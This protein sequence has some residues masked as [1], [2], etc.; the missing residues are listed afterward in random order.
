[1][2]GP[3]RMSWRCLASTTRPTGGSHLGPLAAARGVNRV[4]RATRSEHSVRGA[5]VL[6]RS[7]L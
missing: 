5:V 7:A 4:P 6:N 3:Q 1:M 2:T